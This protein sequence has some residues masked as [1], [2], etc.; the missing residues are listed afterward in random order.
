MIPT[1]YA[2]ASKATVKLQQVFES[3][4]WE[5]LISPLDAGLPFSVGLYLISRHI[6]HIFDPIH[7]E[8]NP[9]TVADTAQGFRHTQGEWET[10]GKCGSAPNIRIDIDDTANVIQA[11]AYHI[12]PN[13]TSGKV[14]GAIA[15]TKTVV[16]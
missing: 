13:P 8:G 6:E 5:Q 3:L 1:I 12:H 2:A 15:R 4:E 9:S 14:I 16:E 10:N 7:W 11:G